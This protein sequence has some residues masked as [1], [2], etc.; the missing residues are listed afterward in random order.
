MEPTIDPAV[1]A[2]AAMRT[3]RDSDADDARRRHRFTARHCRRGS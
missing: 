1:E 2:L 3:L